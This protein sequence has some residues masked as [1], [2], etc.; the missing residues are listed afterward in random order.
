MKSKALP[1]ATVFP[2]RLIEVKLFV[3]LMRKVVVDP[4]VSVRPFVKESAPVPET[5]GT[6]LPPLTIVVAQISS[7]TS[8]AKL[9][10][11]LSF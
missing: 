11:S 4:L 2:M 7:S 10:K 5:P 9:G 1:K 3:A 6:S 8:L